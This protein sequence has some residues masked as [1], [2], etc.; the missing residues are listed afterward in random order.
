[1][2]TVRTDRTAAPG[3]I[4]TLGALSD[5]VTNGTAAAAETARSAANALSPEAGGLVDL[6]PALFGRALVNAAAGAARNPLGVAAASLN[7]A[8][9]LTRATLATTLR[10]L[11]QNTPGPVSPAGVDRRFADPA[12]EENPGFFWLCQSY[13]VLRRLA[14]DLVA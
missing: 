10:A 1:M 11:G 4:L 13:L 14:E 12:W 5:G 7:C 9:D 6:D 3:G 8:V 2:D